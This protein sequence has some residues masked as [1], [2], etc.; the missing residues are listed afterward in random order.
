MEEESWMTSEGLYDED[1]G[2]GVYYD[3]ESGKYYA[4]I[5]YGYKKKSGL[6]KDSK[7]GK[8]KN[9][10]G[11][12]LIMLDESEL[13]D[14]ERWRAKNEGG[15]YRG[16]RGRDTY[17]GPG[18]AV[19]DMAPKGKNAMGF[20]TKS[21]GEKQEKATRRRVMDYAEWYGSEVGSGERGSA[22]LANLKAKGAAT[23][24]M[25]ARY[26]KGRGWGSL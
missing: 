1:L 19:S 9:R 2:G 12:D 15:R 24:E 26:D 6:F 7:L 11:N 16:K 17:R 20:M 3:P 18:R 21:M 4:D 25:R 5:N 10:T 23:K 22:R 14:F 8:G 13:A